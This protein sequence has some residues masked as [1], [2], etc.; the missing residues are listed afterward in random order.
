[1]LGL[2]KLGQEYNQFLFGEEYHA[3]L[4]PVLLQRHSFIQPETLA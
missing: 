1:M 3:L 4:L 2:L